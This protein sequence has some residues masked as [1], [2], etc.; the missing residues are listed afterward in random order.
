LL[1]G[2]DADEAVMQ[3][4]RMKARAL[5]ALEGEHAVN[6]Y[7]VVQGAFDEGPACRFV[8][9]PTRRGRFQI[10][11]KLFRR[12]GRAVSY[13]RI[14]PTRARGQARFHWN[15]ACPPYGAISISVA[16]RHNKH[17][18]SY[19]RWMRRGPN[20]RLYRAMID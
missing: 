18:G 6:A 19:S 15:A 11:S 16:K 20:Q 4:Q 9:R 3:A 8:G 12:A 10:L 17:I 1:F 2:T 13:L 7:S 5:Q 14:A